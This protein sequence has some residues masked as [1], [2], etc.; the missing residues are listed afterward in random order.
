[1]SEQKG[2]QPS[3]TE[4]RQAEASM[5]VEEREH[6]ETREEVFK[7]KSK[8]SEILQDIGQVQEGMVKSIDEKGYVSTDFSGSA[9]FH[10]PEV[11]GLLKVGDRIKLA[12]D[13]EG[14]F[15]GIIKDGEVIWK[16]NY[17][18]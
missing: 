13:N 3:P 1:M 8:L 4:R 10:F 11:A 12:W 14:T 5:S 15:L 7:E 16:P 2:Y 18:R 6:T 17:Q 9:P